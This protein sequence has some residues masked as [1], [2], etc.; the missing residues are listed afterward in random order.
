MRASAWRVAV[1]DTTT[2]SE[3]TST[4]NRLGR[5]PLE[6]DVLPPP[7]P[8][9]ERLTL[10]FN[11]GMG[12]EGG[13]PSGRN[14][15]SGATLDER[16]DYERLRI[17]SVG[18]AV[19]GT[20]GLGMQ[21]LNSYLAAHFQYNQ[22]FSK[23]STA[24]PSLYD[25]NISQ[26]V[27]RSGYVEVDE[28]FSHPLLR[29]IYARAGRSYQYGIAAFQFDGVT[30]GYHTPGLTLSVFGGGRSDTLGLGSDFYVKQG[31]V[32]GFNLRADLFEWNRWP[33]VFSA[34]SLQFD[35]KSHVRT[36]LA[37]RW[38]HDVLLGGS[39]R[40]FDGD[41]AR[42]DLSLAA[43]LSEVTTINMRVHRRSSSDWS[44]GLGHAAPI[45]SNAEARRYLNLGPV[46][47]RTHLSLRY[48]T[49]LLRNID[50]LVRGAGALDGRDSETQNASSYSPSY[51]EG[52]AALE[53]QVRR[54]IRVGTQITA[55]QYFLGKSKQPEGSPE[56]PD[57]L[58]AT[59][60]AT[61]VSS[62]WE[63]GLS[64]FYSPGARIFR[65][66]AEFYTRRY[67]FLSEYLA[68]HLTSYHS[69]GRFSVE[70]WIGQRLRLKTEYDVTVGPLL[71]APELRGLKTLRVLLEGTF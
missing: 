37:L 64:L 39:L 6:Q 54:A 15:L 42:G 2:V 61:G 70:G 17:Y 52:G 31:Q 50:L 32:T 24:L 11:L 27:I 57:P 22:S 4:L 13:Q 41:L 56:R 47:P 12:L 59:L 23:S 55:R 28:I 43:R 46:L 58:P 30:V 1:S 62:F 21:G 66:T 34:A 63:G 8:L 36:G 9:S 20:R 68:N 33:L 18:D 26:P 5:Q 65:G 44:Y 3:P 45:E 67:A 29:P 69:G 49:V 38:N 35:G 53:M 16:D 19:V 10:R 25:Q 7:K 71:A 14:R 51:A 60:A 40:T 48:G